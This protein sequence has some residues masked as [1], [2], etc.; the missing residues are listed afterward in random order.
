MLYVRVCYTRVEF[1]IIVRR[2]FYFY[3]LF[4]RENLAQNFDKIRRRSLVE[5]VVHNRARKKN[6]NWRVVLRSAYRFSRCVVEPAMLCRVCSA[7][8][9]GEYYRMRE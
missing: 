2:D 8:R 7:I 5:N 1:F 6:T 4:C 3:F 9:S